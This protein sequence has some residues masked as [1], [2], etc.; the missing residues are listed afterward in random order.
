[1]ARLQQGTRDRSASGEPV[2]EA[3]AGTGELRA[4]LSSLG[5]DVRDAEGNV[6]EAVLS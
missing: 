2:G 6:A 4:S 5:I 3:A 1:L